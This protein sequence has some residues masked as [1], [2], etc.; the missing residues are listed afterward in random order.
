MMRVKITNIKNKKN[1]RRNKNKKDNFLKKYIFCV[2]PLSNLIFASNILL[3][4]QYIYIIIYKILI[5]SH[6][7]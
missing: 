7:F 1:I 3:N 6:T 2:S 4:M 5:L